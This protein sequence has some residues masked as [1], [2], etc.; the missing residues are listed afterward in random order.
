MNASIKGR[1]GREVA[2]VAVPLD[3]IRGQGTPTSP[4]LT[5]QLYIDFALDGLPSSHALYFQRLRCRLHTQKNEISVWSNPHYLDIRLFEPHIRI[6]EVPAIA[7]FPLTCRQIETLEGLRKGKDIE[8][9]LWFYIE[10]LELVS[11]QTPASRQIRHEDI[12]AIAYQKEYFENLRM[13]CP[14]NIW[15]DQVLP[16]LGYGKIH[17]VEFPAIPLSNIEVYGDAFTALQQAQNFHQIGLYDLAVGQ[18]RIAL[19]KFFQHVPDPKRPEK[20]IPVLNL[21]WINRLGKATY[22]WLN[23][24]LSAIKSDSNVVHH[25]PQRHFSQFDSQMM[26][27]I[28]MALV[29][30][31]ARYEELF[32]ANMTN[33]AG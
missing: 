20:M 18:C 8:L 17:V 31:A 22:D 6:N 1:L 3:K 25:S 9:S 28:T 23:E 32:S 11:L 33:A 2:S 7:E 13:T 16:G 30:Y 5:F 21:K 29:A 14:S 12:W 24:A 26:I 15:I 10:T 19:D 4:V 27:A